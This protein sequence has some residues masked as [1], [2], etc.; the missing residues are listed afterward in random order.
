MNEGCVTIIDDDRDARQMLAMALEAEG[1]EAK[2]VQSGLRLISTLHVDK[3]DVIV[4]EAALS[5]IDGIELCRSIKKNPAFR[6]VPVVII[7]VRRRSEDIV[8]GLQAGAVD[9]F[10]KPVHLGRLIPR[11]REI[12]ASKRDGTQ[13][14]ERRSSEEEEEQQTTTGEGESEE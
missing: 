1:L 14:A 12:L 13:G 2:E 3:P 6:D 11:L 5:W 7:S 10:P 9:Y 4:M 8:A